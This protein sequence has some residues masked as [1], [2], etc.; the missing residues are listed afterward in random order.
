MAGRREAFD[1]AADALGKLGY[2]DE[3]THGALGGLDPSLGTDERL[4]LSLRSLS[5]QA[6]ARHSAAAEA[7][8][9]G[10]EPRG[11]AERPVAPKRPL[12][13]HFDE[14]EEPSEAARSKGLAAGM[15]H[16]D[17][18]KS[19]TAEERRQYRSGFDEAVVEGGPPRRGG[20]QN[21]KNK[22]MPQEPRAKSPE[23]VMRQRVATVNKLGSLARRAGGN[24]RYGRR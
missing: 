16:R 1:E 22:D 12:T 3:E 2:S 19:M 8:G 7:R 11:N 17:R 24:R 9:A 5:D 13:G 18:L 21:P 14:P 10:L 15:E 4:R 23:Q 6:Y 20:M